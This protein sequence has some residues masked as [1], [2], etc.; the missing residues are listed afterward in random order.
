MGSQIILK[1][2][3]SKG[4]VKTKHIYLVDIVS[5]VE[6]GYLQKV[7]QHCTTIWKGILAKVYLTLYQ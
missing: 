7:H 1:T 2:G 3:L 6:K 4:L 5:I